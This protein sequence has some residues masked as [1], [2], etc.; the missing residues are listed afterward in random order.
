M[1]SILVLIAGFFVLSL[2][3]QNYLISF[4][5]TGA[6]TAVDSVKVEN[7]TTGSSVAMKGGDTLRLALIT[8]VN[9]VEVNKFSELKIF[10]NPANSSATLIIY[11]KNEGDATISVYE[12]TGK[13]V[14]QI[15]SYLEP[16]RQDFIISGINTG[17]YLI[18]V[19]GNRYQFSGKLVSNGK[20][21]GKISIR[22]VNT[23]IRAGDK[24]EME[25]NSK[26]IRATLDM[27]YYS[28]NRLKFTGISGVYSTVKTDVPEH[29]KTITFNFIS[30]TD[31]DNNNYPVVEIGTQVWMAENLK[32]TRYSNGDLIG[33]T[34]PPTLSLNTE[35]T[36]KYQWAY[37]GN[38]SNAPVYGRLYTWYASTDSRNVCPAGWHA[39][40]DDEWKTL[41]TYLGGESVA[42]GKLKETGAAHWNWTLLGSNT[43]ATNETGFTA[44][45]GGFRLYYTPSG[46]A[47]NFSG[48]GRLGMWRCTSPSSNDTY[49]TIY[50]D[51][52]RL[53]WI[54]NDYKKNGA[55]IR[56]LKGISPS[57]TTFVS[58]PAGP[59][60][61]TVGG[62]VTSEGDSPV[63]ER[64]VYW[65][66]LFPGGPVS[67]I[68]IGN[69][70]G[71]FSILLSGLEYYR[72]YVVT[73][74]AKSSSGTSYG[75]NILFEIREK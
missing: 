74:Y 61:A 41:A 53:S 3:A 48:I 15:R 31:G 16:T 60:S 58:N 72:Y 27:V 49:L 13:Q 40:S 52:I 43:G 70:P 38:E 6:V 11:P 29:D 17:I 10:P 32:T 71:P 44:L 26:G 45:P 9:S 55:S 75:D 37:D 59:N 22:K 24:K 47:S 23:I 73:A 69:G 8:G 64:G 62:N 39:A 66:A 25:R 7:L 36:P 18:Y 51:E 12:M 1:K 19:K 63:T 68:V 4:S 30:C 65:N 21:G 33:T 42:G 20:S 46:I 35:N 67:K 56:C 50:I 14:A 2:N 54:Y 57:V 34:I 5:G 28:G